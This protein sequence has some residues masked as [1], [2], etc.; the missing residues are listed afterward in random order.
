MSTFD[1]K[2]DY[3]T[4]QKIRQIERVSFERQAR[5]RTR[6]IQRRLAPKTPLA[7][8]QGESYV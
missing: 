5:E 8:Q 2:F 6:E 7:S 3:K 1:S 4:R